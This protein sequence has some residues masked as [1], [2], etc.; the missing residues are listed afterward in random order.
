MEQHSTTEDMKTMS[1]CFNKLVKDGYTEEFKVNDKGI[2][3]EEKQKTY[4]PE[5]VHIVNFFRFEGASDP[6]DNE[7]LYAI[8][9]D[10][11]VKGTL[12]DAYGAY[13]DARVS[14]FIHQ[15]E[16]ITKKP[17]NNSNPGDN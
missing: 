10:D 1:Q 14:K 6:D 11:G 16:D 12:T 9:T 5:K 4:K 15:V 13:A 3:S 7:I 17:V 8:E 2:Y